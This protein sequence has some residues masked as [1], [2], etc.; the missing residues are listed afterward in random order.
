MKDSIYMRF[1]NFELSSWIKKSDIDKINDHFISNEQINMELKSISQKEWD[2]QC[3]K[4]DELL[5]YCMKDCGNRPDEIIKAV[6]KADLF[7]FGAN[8]NISAAALWTAYLKWLDEKC[9]V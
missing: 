9:A 3:A 1:E 2:K 5:K 4:V 7:N 6:M 8:N